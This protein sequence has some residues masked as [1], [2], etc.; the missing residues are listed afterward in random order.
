MD[1][2]T[3]MDQMDPESVDREMNA[4]DSEY[5]MTLT[6]DAWAAYGVI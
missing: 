4:V 2:I 6:D 3:G 5:S 1:A